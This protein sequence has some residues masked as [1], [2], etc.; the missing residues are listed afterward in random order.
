[1]V[2]LLGIGILGL[3]LAL[4]CAAT[5]EDAG[6]LLAMT[7]VGPTGEEANPMGSITITNSADLA[8]KILQPV[9][10]SED[11]EIIKTSEV[12]IMGTGKAAEG[13]L[14]MLKEIGVSAVRT[15][16]GVVLIV[17]ESAI[18]ILEELYKTGLVA[19]NLITDTV[20]N[21]VILG[22]NAIVHTLK[23]VGN[24]LITGAIYAADILVKAAEGV[25]WLLK[26]LYKAAG[27]V[28]TAAASGAI[29]LVHY[30]AKGI[31][32]LVQFIE[33]AV[34]FVVKFTADMVV[35]VIKIVLDGVRY[36]LDKTREAINAVF[37]KVI[38]KEKELGD[39]AVE[40][41]KQ[42]RNR[43]WDKLKDDLKNFGKPKSQERRNSPEP[44]P[45]PDGDGS[46]AIRFGQA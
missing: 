37:Q 29:L 32:K 20:K 41:T 2:R 11:D 38:E 3:L 40:S 9:N 35:G 17:G 8:K 13:L 24:L 12:I 33:K 42:T 25:L 45:Q 23:V 28:L 43:A 16:G 39:K 36:M 5:Y 1:M 21:M 22:K 19:M 44:T 14:T 27:Y 30:A 18:A 46:M 15:I 7:G 10:G 26:G 34:M 4:P 31:V 6:K